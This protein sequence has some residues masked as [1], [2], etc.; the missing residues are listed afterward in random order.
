M[1]WVER[2]LSLIGAGWLTLVLSGCAA[3][4]E[5]IPPVDP[6]SPTEATI[7]TALGDVAFAAEGKLRA[8][9]N[10]GAWAHYTHALRP[11][12]IGDVNFA[13]LEAVVTQKPLTS[14]ET[15]GAGF[16]MHTTGLK[17]LVEDLGFN[18]LST[19]NDRSGDFGREGQLSTLAALSDYDDRVIHHGLGTTEA[20]S[21]A[22]TGRVG[23]QEIAFAA[24]GLSDNAPRPS[25]SGQ[26]GQWSVVS[27]PDWEKTVQAMMR[28]GESFKVLSL[29]EG[30][31]Y[32][33]MPEDHVINRFRRAQFRADLDLIIAHHSHVVRGLEMDV[34]GRVIAY[35]LGNGM[36]HGAVDLS[37]RGSTS[38]FGLMLRLYYRRSAMGPVL[39][40]LEAIPLTSVHRAPRPMT[41][42]ASKVRI[43][44][45]NVLSRE[46]SNERAL[47]LKTH[48]TTGFGL[49]CRSMLQTRQ[50][51]DLCS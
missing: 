21:Q 38:D 24:L 32:E 8:G 19:A 33:Q 31:E 40:A 49:W 14:S 26:P 43:R 18:L 28:R 7:V 35:G 27:P 34:K 22:K 42:S 5:D 2:R 6:N 46:T 3:V 48:A 12:I 36:L 37:E 10:K 17:H 16:Q 25:S 13:N 45:L 4:T 11:L 44:L 15:Q 51:I 47:E 1:A 30:L 50:A 41:P 39:E 29:H 20:L 23:E 9:A